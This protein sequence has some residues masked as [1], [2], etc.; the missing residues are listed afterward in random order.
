MDIQKVCILYVK[1]TDFFV[2]IYMGIYLSRYLRRNR[3]SRLDK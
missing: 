2:F 3:Y 1:D